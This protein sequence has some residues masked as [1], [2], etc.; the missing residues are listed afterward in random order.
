MFSFSHIIT[1]DYKEMYRVSVAGRVELFFLNIYSSAFSTLKICHLDCK[2]IAFTIPRV[3]YNVG[4]QR[5]HT[6]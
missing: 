3:Q 1:V 5:V 6:G 4:L 2:A